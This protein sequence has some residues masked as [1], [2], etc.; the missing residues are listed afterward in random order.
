M[1]DAGIARIVGEVEGKFAGRGRGGEADRGTVVDEPVGAIGEEFGVVSGGADGQDAATGGF[2]GTDAG[3]SVFDDDAVGRGKA[4][5]GGSGEVGLGIRLTKLDVGGGDEMACEFEEAGGAEAH[6][7]EP[8]RGG[9]DHGELAG[10]DGGEEF[11]R[12]GEGDDVGDIVDLCLLQPSVFPEM[13]GIGGVREERLDG[14]ETGAAVS[15]FDDEFG[16]HALPDGPVGPGA[17]HGGGGIDENAVH[18]EEQAGAEDTG[19]WAPGERNKHC[20]VKTGG[21]ERPGSI[22]W[23]LSA[24]SSWEIAIKVG[25]GKLVLPERP[26]EFVTRAIRIMSLQSLDITHIHALAVFELPGHHRDPFDRLLIAQAQTEGMTILT[27][28]PIFQKYEVEQIFCGE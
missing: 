20:G 12:T 1:R 6:F 3:R 19:H 5:S 15:G 16:N 11:T 24:V 22:E 7:G 25:I 8:A 4:E 27:D 18:I 14:S 26:A 28:D 2:A 10:R 9:S 17:G 23:F 21:K 13:N